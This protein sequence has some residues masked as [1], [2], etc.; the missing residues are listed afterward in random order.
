M[1]LALLLCAFTL[2][3]APAPFPKTR[4][5]GGQQFASLE[6]KWTYVAQTIG[7][8]QLPRE[9]RNEIWVEIQGASYWRCGT[10]GVRQESRLTLDPKRQPK[11]FTLTFTHPISGKVS[12]SKGI[13]RLDGDRLTLCYNATGNTRPAKFESPEGQEGVVLSVLRRSS[14]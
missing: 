7:G 8:W 3:F 1:R 10:G 9:S 11:E 14:K 2:A 5:R 12:V 13:Y 6:G 4:E